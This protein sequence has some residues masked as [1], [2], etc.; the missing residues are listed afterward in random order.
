ME[1]IIQGQVVLIDDFDYDLVRSIDWHIK[2]G[3]RD[4][5]RYVI[6]RKCRLIHRVLMGLLPK[7]KIH[8]D[9][10]NGNGLDNRRSNLRFAT[11]EQN[12]RNRRIQKFR[13]GI[14]V[15]S[16]YKGVHK[17]RRDGDLYRSC[18]YVSKKRVH[19]GYYKN[20][21]DA[22]KAYNSAAVLYYGEFAKLN[23]V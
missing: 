5:T 23:Q 21:L 6:A 12:S 20:E 2:R 8:V 14:P 18:I 1:I 3:T 7:D 4:I 10:I 9:H 11:Q 22:A 13:A 17:H 16:K 19:L 15:T